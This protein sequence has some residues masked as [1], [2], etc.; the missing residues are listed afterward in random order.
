[1]RHQTRGGFINKDQVCMIQ[2]V[3]H[4]AWFSEH[5][6]G[7]E[8]HGGHL[9]QQLQVQGL[10]HP[11]LVHRC[12]SQVFKLTAQDP[13]GLDAVTH[14]MHKRHTMHIRGPQR[15]GNNRSPRASPELVL[16]SQ[17]LPAN[18]DPN[19]AEQGAKRNVLGHGNDGSITSWSSLLWQQRG[20]TR[21]IWG[22]TREWS[23]GTSATT[24]AP[25]SSR[26]SPA[27]TAPSAMTTSSSTAPRGPKTTHRTGSSGSRPVRGERVL[28]GQAYCDKTQGHQHDLLFEFVIPF[29][30]ALQIRTTIEKIFF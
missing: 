3:C 1:M 17:W 22:R 24:P 30:D 15:K 14:T 10:C 25:T 18:G 6:P 11:H 21:R 7:S 26:S 23:M 19:P 12:S 4:G 27:A 5:H 9:G 16:G 20:K 29:L 8:P 2:A 28:F 13:S